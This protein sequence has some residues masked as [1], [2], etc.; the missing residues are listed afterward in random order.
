MRLRLPVGLLLLLTGLVWVGQGLGYV[1]GSF[2]TDDLAWAAIGA[3]TAAIGALLAL[4]GW[5]D[6]RSA[7]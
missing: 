2:M 3:L 7:G 4:W 6:R 5:R 1:G